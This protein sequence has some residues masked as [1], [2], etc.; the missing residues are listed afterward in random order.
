MTDHAP[1]DFAT[2]LQAELDHFEGKRENSDKAPPESPRAFESRLADAH[3]RALDARLVGLALSGGGIRSA[4]FNLGVLQALDDY[5]LLAGFHYLS[6]VS[7]GGYIGSWLTALRYWRTQNGQGT[8]EETDR[9]LGI[10]SGSPGEHSGPGLSEM[11]QPGERPKPEARAVSFLRAFSNYLTPRKGFLSADSWWMVTTYLRNLILNLLLLVAVLV[12]ILLVVHGVGAGFS[13]LVRSHE[14]GGGLAAVLICGIVAWILGV[15]AAGII[16]YRVRIVR[17]S[18]EAVSSDGKRAVGTLPQPPPWSLRAV[19]FLPFLAVLALTCAWSLSRHIGP[20]G[21][22]AGSAA[23]YLLAWLVGGL[24]GIPLGRGRAL[25]THGEDQDLGKASKG[26]PPLKLLA[27]T[28]GAALLAGVLALWARALIEACPE[29]WSLFVWGPPIVALWLAL[30]VL[31]HLGLAGRW[32]RDAENEWIGRVGAWLVIAAMAWILST[33]IRVYGPVLLVWAGPSLKGLLGLLWGGITVTGVLSMPGGGGGQGRAGRLLKPVATVA[34]FVFVVGLLCLLAAGVDWGLSHDFALTG[35]EPSVSAPAPVSTADP[36]DGATT[37]HPASSGLRFRVGQHAELL[38]AIGV[39]GPFLW[40]LVASVGVFGLLGWRLDINEFSMHPFY[41]NRLIRCFLG[42]PLP[43]ENVREQRDPFTGFTPAADL[44]L[45]QLVWHRLYPILNTSMGLASGKAL[46]WQDRKAA[47]F[48]FTPDYCGYD[49]EMVARASEGQVSGGGQAAYA[50]TSRWGEGDSRKLTLGMA[51]AISGAAVSSRLGPISTPALSFLAT[52]FNV[53]LGY[54]IGNPRNTKAWKRGSPVFGIKYLLN[55]LRGAVGENQPFVNLTDGGHFEN[56][57]I[58]ELIHRRCRFI[59]ASD[60]SGDG[61][62]NFSSLAEAVRKVR[63]DFGIEIDLDTAPLAPGGDGRG[64]WHCVVGRIHYDAVHPGAGEGILLYLK[65]TLTG[66]E[67]SDLLSYGRS[68]PA[69]PHQSTGDQWF[70]EAQFESYRR[71]GYHVTSSALSEAVRA[72]RKQNS[73]AETAAPNLES[74]YFFLGQRWF[75]PSKVSPDAI[76]WETEALSK[77]MEELRTNEHLRFLYDDFYIDWH[78]LAKPTPK[79]GPPPRDQNWLE[80]PK[81]P[82]EFHEG[83]FFCCSL[84]K[85][86]E[87]IYHDLRLEAEHEHPDHRGWINL[88]KHWTWSPTFRLTWAVT[89]GTYGA[90]FQTFCWLHLGLEVGKVDVQQLL[91]ADDDSS[92]WSEGVGASRREPAGLPGQ[93]PRNAARKLS[94]AIDQVLARPHRI[95]HLNFHERDWVTRLLAAA[96]DL[97]ATESS[98]VA[99]DTVWGLVLEMRPPSFMIG[100]EWRGLNTRSLLFGFALTAGDKLVYFRVRDHLRRLGLGRRGLRELLRKTR[101]DELDQNMTLT[102]ARVDTLRRKLDEQ[103]KA[104][105]RSQLSSAERKTRIDFSGQAAVRQ[106]LLSVR[107]EQATSQQS[108]REWS[109]SPAPTTGNASQRAA[110][111]PRRP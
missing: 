75:P 51:M 60:A 70:D 9:P 26:L 14:Q 109:A 89:A 104:E 6:T 71:L 4:T 73:S 29:P 44:D 55:E 95:H 32:L 68:H 56:L 94:T 106:L 17:A 27:V 107:A 5:R 7:G 76:A 101:S 90:R 82:D 34:P 25:S 52:V 46:A 102:V 35:R 36:I 96:A 100:G 40:L 99:V 65:P 20:L 110:T 79:E 16:S 81:Q 43:E 10:G 39:G 80:L 91:S 54:W 33:G 13:G 2:V 78:S 83:F 74:V 58:Y 49:G 85:L 30:V 111:P 67:P 77:L 97:Q 86:M 103:R 64:A 23:L 84:I 28:V 15:V 48:F 88:F 42:A 37:V 62:G 38:E 8:P 69:F 72:A 22:F 61:E 12:F 41:R 18:I 50:K 21:M 57:G 53:R 63:T 31:L 93:E 47:S 108:R 59:L 87:S 66:D 105:A 11:E 98:E 1:V 19:E 92:C 45:D 24:F 3:E